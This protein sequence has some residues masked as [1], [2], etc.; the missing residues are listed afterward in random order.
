MR[1]EIDVRM[2]V[3][4]FANGGRGKDSRMQE[5]FKKLEKKKKK[6]EKLR[7]QIL[8]WSCQKEYN[9]ADIFFFFFLV[10]VSAGRLLSCGSLAP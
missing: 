1:N 10:L 3:T 9:P 7:K 6:L 4:D 8:L 2:I 5:V